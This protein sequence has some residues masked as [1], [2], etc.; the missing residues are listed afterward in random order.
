MDELLLQRL[1]DGFAADGFRMEVERTGDHAVVT[2]TPDGGDDCLIPK[3][4]LTGYLRN[5]L[6]LDAARIEVRYPEGA[7]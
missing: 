1:Q 6:D 5:A 3:A 7:E 2:V 4:T